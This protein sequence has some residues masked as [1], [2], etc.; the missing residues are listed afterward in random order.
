MTTHIIWKLSWQNAKTN[1]I[2]TIV[3]KQLI[4]QLHI[5]CFHHKFKKNHF[6]E[7]LVHTLFLKPENLLPTWCSRT[8]WLNSQAACSTSTHGQDFPAS[9]NCSHH[10]RI[11][12]TLKFDV[13]CWWQSYKIQSSD[14]PKWHWAL[15]C[16]VIPRLLSDQTSFQM[17][18]QTG[19]RYVNYWLKR[20]YYHDPWIK[21]TCQVATYCHGY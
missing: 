16:Y 15:L 2:S 13:R 5:Q 20:V 19:G 8:W 14:F 4:L 3:I 7:N 9:Y 17:V 21:V 1:Y 11:D 18:R 6:H 10:W 12:R